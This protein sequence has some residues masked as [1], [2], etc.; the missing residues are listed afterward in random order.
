MGWICAYMDFTYRC[1]KK[2]KSR[3]VQVWVEWMEALVQLS[4]S[5]VFL[6]SLPR[7]WRVAK[8]PDEELVDAEYRV[9]DPGIKFTNTFA[10]LPGGGAEKER[11]RETDWKKSSNLAG[12]QY[13]VHG[14]I[15]MTMAVT[16]FL[17]DSS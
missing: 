9:S 8:G 15:D 1:K 6:R 16:R 13:D 5:A 10:T 4:H 17:C 2:A 7:Q 3:L 14:N 11:E 12:S